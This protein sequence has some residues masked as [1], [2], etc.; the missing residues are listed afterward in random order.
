MYPF[1]FKPYDFINI[2]MNFIRLF[3]SFQSIYASMSRR[4]CG[5]NCANSAARLF[6]AAELAQLEGYKQPVIVR[7]G[8][9]A[10][11]THAAFIN[12]RKMDS[13]LISIF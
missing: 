3:L 4:L 7:L 2:L 9:G 1:C 5:S 6:A 12:S 8:G 13:I 11:P 10:L